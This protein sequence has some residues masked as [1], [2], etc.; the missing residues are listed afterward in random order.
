MLSRR[1]FT[2]AVVASAMSSAAGYV[3]E[4]V[5]QERFPTKP[6]RFIYPLAPG[7]GVEAVVRH[8]AEKYGQRLGHPMIVENKP[9]ANMQIGT[10]YVA[11]SSPD[12]YTIG[13]GFI[14]NLTLAP[15]V[16]RSL[17]YDPKKELV[18]IGL[19]GTN[20]MALT[21]RADAPY[22]TA[23]ELAKWANSKPNGV[24]VA[25]TG[26]GAFPHLA[27]ELLGRLSP[28]PFRMVTYNGN[29]PIQADVIGGVVDVAMTD[30]SGAAGLIQSGKLKLLG[31]SSPTRDPRV[32][33]L[34]TIA[35]S[36][37]GYQALGWFGFV[38]PVGTPKPVI[39]VLNQ[40]LNG[41]VATKEV[42]ESMAALGLT[43]ITGS[44]DDFSKLL[45]NENEK[46]AALIQQIGFKPL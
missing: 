43:S 15:L 23:A 46:Y 9:G 8:I 24:T 34:P 11:K 19:F 4:V 7:G 39:E 21:T 22:S 12:G 35:E 25:V 38:A 28:M 41:A 44:P 27:F 36:V 16:F 33:Q 37:P 2:N 17:P 40:V 3:R 13:L 42:Q 26:V 30:Y 31:I 5:A 18:P 32:P 6:M 10:N 20:Y 14:S 1:S 29:G 45:E